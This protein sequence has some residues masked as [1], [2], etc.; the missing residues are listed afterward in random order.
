MKGN[1]AVLNAV[2][3]VLGYGP[4]VTMDIIN[5][6]LQVDNVLVCLLIDL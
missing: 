5:R 3:T 2:E 6:M 1:S 4:N